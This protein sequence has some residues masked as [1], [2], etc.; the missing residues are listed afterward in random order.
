MVAVND[1]VVPVALALLQRR[2]LKFEGSDPSA[3][4]LRV[5]GERKLSGIVVPRAKQMHCFAIAGS[6]QRE[7]E[8]DSGHCDSDPKS[9]G[10]IKKELRYQFF[11]P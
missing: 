4:L 11:L 6:A 10:Q 7:V 5:L 1:V 2:S 8:L 3:A 9:F